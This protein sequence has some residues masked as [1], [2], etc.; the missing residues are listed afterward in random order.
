[1]DVPHTRET[2]VESRR[3][4]RTGLEVSEIGFGAF[5]IGR[6]WGTWVRDLYQRPDEADAVRTLNAVLDSGI[7]FIDTAP[8]YELSEERIGK[9]ISHRRSEFILATKVGERRD[10]GDEDSTYDYTPEATMA[11]I[12][13]SLKRMRTDVIDLVQIHSAPFDVICAGDTLGAMNRA[14]EQGKVRHV[15]MS[16]G[17]AEAIQA[18]N[19]GGYDTVE[20]SFSIAY[21]DAD[22]ELFDLARQNDVGVIIKDGLAAG[23][24]TDKAEHL[25]DDQADSREMARRLSLECV[26]EY[27]KPHTDGTLAELALR[28][29]L[30]YDA[31]S[32]IIAGSRSIEHVIAN[33]AVSDGRTLTAEQIAHVIEVA[34]RT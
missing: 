14:K 25:G 18:V 13:E 34:D 19:D 12:E 8:A 9:A 33:V 16:G 1:M 17:V 7:N 5:E 15:G 21:R 22:A 26:K 6:T 4:G 30:S 20:V 32:T 11:F 24:L 29:A 28:F 27:A 2:R 3:L 23:L 10:D 31:V